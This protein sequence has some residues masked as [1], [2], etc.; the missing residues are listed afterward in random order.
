MSVFEHL[1]DPLH[2]FFQVIYPLI[3]QFA[4]LS[5]IL[6]AV[7]KIPAFCTEN[8]SSQKARLTG[9]SDNQQ[10]SERA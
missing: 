4:P 1:Q 7:G 5:I 8:F 3:K 2:L 6:A 10:D 9:F